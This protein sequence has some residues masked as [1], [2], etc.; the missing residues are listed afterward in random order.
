MTGVRART[1]GGLRVA[2]GVDSSSVAEE[3][4][5]RVHQIQGFTDKVRCSNPL[6][7]SLVFSFLFPSSLVCVKYVCV[8][9][10]ICLLRLVLLFSPKP[11]T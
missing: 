6:C 1:P 5:V 2:A 10:R 9:T 8:F 4:G 11:F 7:L 3:D